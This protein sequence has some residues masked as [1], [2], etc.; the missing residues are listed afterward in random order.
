MNELEYIT[1]TF[2]HKKYILESCSLLVEFLYKSGRAGEAKALANRCMVHDASKMS[3]KELQGFIKLNNIKESMTN[4]ASKLN[5][6]E[7]EIISVHW[8]NNRHHP[9][10]F[11][12]Y[13]DMTE[14]DI[15]EMCCDWHSRSKEYGT[16]FLDFVK[17]RQKNRF[18]FDKEFFSR[19]FFYC[20]VLE[21]YDIS[22]TV[23]CKA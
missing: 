10:Y 18:H 19:V 15:M 23:T 4:S 3:E 13:H 21:E 6:Y 7:K 20:C 5:D 11:D 14:I 2:K 16:N 1:E 17:E 8:K 22:K 12:D 9:E